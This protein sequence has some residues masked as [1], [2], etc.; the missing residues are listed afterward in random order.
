VS[1]YTNHGKTAS[2][3]RNSGR[4]STVT[5]R[6]TDRRTLRRTVS[7]YQSYC[8]TG[9]S[10]TDDCIHLGSAA[11]AKSLLTDSSAQIRKPWRHDHKSQT[12][13]NCKHEI[14]SYDS[15]SFT[16]CPTLGRVYIWRTPSMECL[17]RTTKHWGGSV[18]VWAAIPSYS[19]A[20]IINFP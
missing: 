3:K 13:D 16:L 8:N 6:E 5:E 10:R 7:K 9:D 20:P 14:W 19:V 15:S 17:V 4:Q 11:V 2:A 12:S 1:A 18:M